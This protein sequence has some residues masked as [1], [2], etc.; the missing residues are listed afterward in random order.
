MLEKG[1]FLGATLLL[2]FLLSHSATSATIGFMPPVNYPVG[3]NPG[4]VAVGD[5]NGDGKTDLAVVNNGNA[6]TG[7]D[8][9]V[10]ILLGNG[11]GTFQAAVNFAA[12]K[13]P[14]SI[15]VGDFNGDGRVDLVTANSDN[16]VSV[17]L[18]NGDGTFQA[19]VDYATSSGPVWVAVGDFNGD[20]RPDLVVANSGG[21][22]VSVLLGNGDGTFQAHVDYPTGGSPQVLAVADFNQ[23]GKADLAVAAGNGVVILAGNGDGTFT[24]VWTSGPLFVFSTSVAVGDF[25]NHGKLDLVVRGI[26]FGNATAS[27]LTFL[28]GN[29]DGTF[30]SGSTPGTGACQNKAPIAADFNGDG[31]LDLALFGDDECLPNPKSNPRVLV[32]AGNADGTFQAAVNVGGNLTPLL[33]ADLDGNKSPD[34]VALN[35]ATVNTISV[36]L[37]TV[38]PDFSLS[39][40]PLSPGTVNGGQTA[41]STV[42]LTLLNAFDNSVSLS[43]LV[44]PAQAGSPTCSISP[45][46]VV[47]DASGAASA[48]LT[49][50]AGASAL[51]PQ[52]ADG[53]DS[54]SWLFLWLPIVG[55]AVAGVGFGRNNSSRRKL[56]GLFVGCFLLAGLIFQSACGG[57]SSG[58]KSKAYTVTVTGTSGSTQ[59]STT[60]TLTVQ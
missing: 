24:Q 1:R 37:N 29:G 15:A 44:Q 25:T 41:T 47:F 32:L 40:S 59:R 7:D 46:Q 57:S 2:M 22:S 9:N 3:T 34:L 30:S 12:G 33:A 31:K 55:F 38:G 45:N 20:N 16:T 23:D 49:A 28:T 13:N 51:L 19:H 52:P 6:S 10:S 35:D 14:S 4:A 11:D 27:S 5:F 58:P 54:R 53:Q 17:L 48:Q 8:G 42:T 56:L 60:V 26:N 39:A 18:G 21:S 43:C 50:T 36:L